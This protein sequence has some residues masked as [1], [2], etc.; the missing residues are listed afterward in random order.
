METTVVAWDGGWIPLTN[1]RLPRVE[2][3][4]VDD[5][6]IPTLERNMSV[7]WLVD[8]SS[9]SCSV[10]LQPIFGAFEGHTSPQLC[11]RR[12]TLVLPLRYRLF[13]APLHRASPI[14]GGGLDDCPFGVGW[15]I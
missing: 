11:S 14:W 3:G 9:P 7:M 6:M 5:G 8:I 10:G 4:S 1:S 13:L 12:A 2:P 15:R